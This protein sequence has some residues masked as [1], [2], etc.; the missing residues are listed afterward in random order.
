VAARNLKGRSVNIRLTSG[1]QIKTS[2]IDVTAQAL[3]IRPTRGQSSISKERIASIRFRGNTGHHGL[4]GDLIGLGADVGAAI[5]ANSDINEGAFVVILPV[6]AALIAIG[7]AVAVQDRL[8][9]LRTI[10]NASGAR[11]LFQQSIKT[12]AKLPHG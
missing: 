12:Q 11:V 5:A 8:L 1:E 3:T 4:T 9:H 2:L 7:G 10:E 6:I